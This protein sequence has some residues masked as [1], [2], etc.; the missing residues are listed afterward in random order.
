MTTFGGF[1]S[2]EIEIL[3]RAAAEG[4]EDAKAVLRRYHIP[5]A[6]A[7]QTHETKDERRI[8]LTRE[9]HERIV[10]GQ[11]PLGPLPVHEPVT[12]DIRDLRDPAEHGRALLGR[13]SGSV[14]DC[15]DYLDRHSELVPKFNPTG[16]LGAVTAAQY[17]AELTQRAAMGNRFATSV[18]TTGQPGDSAE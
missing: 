1:D 16:M 15:A 13:I 17:Q 12:R 3:E 8:R 2:G 9:H 6:L 10:S 7:M 5:P 18:L 11:L 14:C 4:D